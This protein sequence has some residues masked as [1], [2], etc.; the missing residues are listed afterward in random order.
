MK[1]AILSPSA[2]HR[3]MNC[4]K[5]ARAEEPFEDSPSPAA[6]E[7]TVAH[8]ICAELLIELQESGSYNED[9][10]IDHVLHSCDG[11]TPSEFDEW[12]SPDMLSYAEQYAA[13]VWGVYQE[14]L[15]NTPDAVL[16]IEKKVDASM[17]GEGMTG[18]TDAAI[19]S[20]KILHIFDFKFGRGVIVS[21]KGNPQMSI[22]ALA[23]I[24]QYGGM[25]AFKKVRETIYQPRIG[26]ISTYETTV[27]ELKDF[28]TLILAPAAKLAYEGGGSY[29]AGEWCK[30]CR[31]KAICGKE[32]EHCTEDFKKDS[33]K[34]AS[35]LTNEEIAKIINLSDE[36]M[37][38]LDAVKEYASSQLISGNEI[39][40]LKLVEGR[41]IR[42]Y[43]DEKKVIDALHGNGFNDEQIFERKLKTITSMQ[44]TLTKKVFDAVLNGLIIKP[45]GSPTLAKDSDP[46]PAYNSAQD[47]FKNIE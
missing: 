25:Y 20:D 29:E 22:Y 31:V 15:K 30:F 11:F 36:I 44:K 41:S 32:A 34:D 17:Y 47:D 5:S 16:M 14:E 39:E 38:W 10:A 37:A 27:K 43:A 42:K 24:E 9:N 33:Q 40:G 2:A 12:Y 45:K 28:G 4:T 13:Y 7:G 6:T 8:A 19:V 46:R 1:H 21:A 23:N 35:M 3:W 18:T 26:N